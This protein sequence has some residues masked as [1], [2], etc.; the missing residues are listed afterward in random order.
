MWHPNKRVHDREGILPG[1]PGAYLVCHCIA[2][3]ANWTRLFV[4]N[5]LDMHSCSTD[6]D[7]THR[8]DGMELRPVERLEVTSEAENDAP[9]GQTPDGRHFHRQRH[10]ED[11]HP[12][13]RVANPSG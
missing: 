11:G 8:L 7:D 13:A 12:V 1:S 6:Y 2:T 5:D 3:G 10:V 9:F 4:S